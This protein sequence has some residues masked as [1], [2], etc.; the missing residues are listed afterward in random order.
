L[1]QKP[2]L[3]NDTSKSTLTTERKEMTSGNKRTKF[4]IASASALAL[5]ASMFAAAS[6]AVAAGYSIGVSNSWAGN[7]WREE[8]VCAIKAQAT[9]TGKYDKVLVSS[10]NT[11][12][13]GQSADIRSF[14]TQKVNAIIVNSG[15]TSA[16]NPAMEE[17]I[18][19]GIK[20]IAVDNSVTAKGVTLVSND[21]VKYGAVG[22]EALAKAM[23]YKGN[24]L[25]MRG[26]SGAGADTDRDKGFRAVMKKYP[27]MKIAKEVF[28]NWD[29]AKG[30]E[31]ANQLLVPGKFQGVWTSGIDYPVVEA[32]GKRLNGKYIPLVGADNNKFLQQTAQLASKG[33]VGIVVSNPAVIGGAALKV[34]TDM[35][36]GK[37]VP[38][39][40]LITPTAWTYKS[41][42][43]EIDGLFFKDQEATFSSAIKIPG[44]TN[45]TA[46]QLFRCKAPQDSNDGSR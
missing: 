2:Y 27:N 20:V 38:A 41:N 21:Q 18:A 46:A 43:K 7:A 36:D 12:A 33:F 42:K 34:A 32:M 37:S 31:L 5:V 3:V 10:R 1:L 22:A 8:M 13:A 4:A 14:I 39:S 6:P 28:T 45:F 24:V 29:W 40:N 30:G 15:D 26:I 16:N 44:Y 11:D 25:Y 23:G 19:A 35:L 9:N 17:A